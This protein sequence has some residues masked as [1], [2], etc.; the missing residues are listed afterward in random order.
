MSPKTTTKKIPGAV[1]PQHTTRKTVEVDPKETI[2]QTDETMPSEDTTK[3]TAERKATTH[4]TMATGLTIWLNAE[5]GWVTVPTG[6]GPWIEREGDDDESEDK[7]E[8]SPPPPFE[9]EEGM[10]SG[11]MELFVVGHVCENLH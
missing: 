9:G 2:K 1:A 7:W 8:D 4:M 6:G 10:S 3:E 5:E 11:L